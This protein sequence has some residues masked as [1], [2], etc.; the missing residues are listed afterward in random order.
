[1]F[2]GSNSMAAEGRIRRAR[3]QVTFAWPVIAVVAFCAAVGVLWPRARYVPVGAAV[4][5]MPAPR[6]AFVEL[7]EGTRGFLWPRSFTQERRGEGVLEMDST[8]QRP[9]PRMAFR[10]WPEL[11]ARAPY[12]HGEQDFATLAPPVAREGELPR[13]VE[14][15]KIVMRVEGGLSEIGFEVQGDPQAW[16]EV[17]GEGVYW[18]ELGEDGRVAHVLV[19]E[20]NGDARGVMRRW[21]ER[22][23]GRVVATGRGIVRVRWR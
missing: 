21:L 13:V 19:L 12:K 11:E 4:L 10:E 3:R 7:P 23:R 9:L 18:V 17:A 1:M 14:E 8:M 15:K 6:M 2:Q 20:G 22:G 16:P 5:K